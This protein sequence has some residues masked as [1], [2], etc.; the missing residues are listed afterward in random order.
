MI[1]Q[2]ETDLPMTSSGPKE[3][4]SFEPNPPSDSDGSSGTRLI[5]GVVAM[6]AGAAFLLG[7][8]VLWAGEKADRLVVFPWAGRVA[9]LVGTAGLAIGA[10]LD[11]RDASPAVRR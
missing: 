5:V 3:P 11:T 7:G 6:L 10:A 1:Q 4:A 9:M 8:F 2:S